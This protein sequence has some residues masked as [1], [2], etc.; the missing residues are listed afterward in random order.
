MSANENKLNA[1]VGISVLC[2][3]ITIVVRRPPFSQKRSD[4]VGG[5]PNIRYYHSYW[6][7][8]GYDN[9]PARKDSSN[10]PA[11]STDTADASTGDPREGAGVRPLEL[12]AQQFLAR[13]S[14]LPVGPHGVRGDDRWGRMV[15]VGTRFIPDPVHNR[16]SHTSCSRFDDVGRHSRPRSYFTVHVNKHTAT[17]RADGSVVVVVCASDPATTL[18]SASNE[19]QSHVMHSPFAIAARRVCRVLVGEHDWSHRGHDVVALD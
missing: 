11:T 4:D 12:P 18:V 2:E 19:R 6:Q 1:N 8:C 17:L 7:V 14:G 16:P 9:L 13:E 3:C 15:C 10:A 5:D